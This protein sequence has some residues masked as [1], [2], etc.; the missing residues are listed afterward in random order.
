MTS[1]GNLIGN[2]C[3]VERL[4]TKIKSYRLVISANF[5]FLFYCG[6]LNCVL[7]KLITSSQAFMRRIGWSLLKFGAQ[8]FLNFDFLILQH[9]FLKLQFNI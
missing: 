1:I 9:I 6:N 7:R 5:W 2:P 8:W 4:V 3:I